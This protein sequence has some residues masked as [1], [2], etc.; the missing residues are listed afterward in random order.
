MT[1]N[2]E[3]IVS[4][5]ATVGIMKERLEHV[6]GKLDLLLEAYNREKYGRE[7]VTQVGKWTVWLIV[8][9][10]SAFHWD[11]ILHFFKDI[12]TK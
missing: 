10:A 2:I 11:N 7:V 5:E 6:D 1:E 4:L 12:P 8:L 9:A 3:R